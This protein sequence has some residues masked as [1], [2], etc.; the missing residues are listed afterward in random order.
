M[1]AVMA[2]AAIAPSLPG[3]QIALGGSHAELGARVALTLP[4]LAIAA[5]APLCGRVGAQVGWSKLLVASLVAY[6]MLGTLGSWA[7]DLLTMWLLRAAFGVAVAG[8]MTSSTALAAELTSPVERPR[9]FGQQAA[10]MSLGGVLFVALGGLLASVHW[11]VPFSLYALALP[12]AWLGH[13]TL[14][15]SSASKPARIARPTFVALPLVAA[16][17]M[18]LYFFVPTQL[19][20]VPLVRSPLVAGLCIASASLAGAATSLGFARSLRWRSS[21]PAWL[22]VSFVAIG[23][24]YMWI[25]YAASLLPMVLGLL[26]AGAGMGLVMPNLSTWLLDDIQPAE[27]AGAIGMLTSCVFLGQFLSPL[28]AHGLAAEAVSTRFTRAG[29]VACVASAAF[30]A[31]GRSR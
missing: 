26:L 6:A 4:A 20:F 16:F 13:R 14:P 10:C 24:G 17:A 3:M 31:R 29:L 30:A 18:A 8:V 28:F 27:R 15:T 22:S 5:C 21:R 12:L 7:P 9:F 25:G 11:R 2:S 19:P 1:L 23:V